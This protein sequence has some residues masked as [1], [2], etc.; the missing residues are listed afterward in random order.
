MSGE[1]FGKF[2]YDWRQKDASGTVLRTIPDMYEYAEKVVKPEFDE[3]MTYIG[4][5]ACVHIYTCMYMQA[6][7]TNSQFLNYSC[8]IPI[9]SLHNVTD[10]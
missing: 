8:C 5:L 4:K 1:N 7:I 2:G 3:L 10:V 9:I 6:N